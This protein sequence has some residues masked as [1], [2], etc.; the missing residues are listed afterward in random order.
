MDVVDRIMVSQ[1]FPQS[2]TWNLQ[3]CEVIEK[4]TCRCAQGYG[5]GD[6]R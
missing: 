2:N 6:G 5:P 3:T 1:G 4:M